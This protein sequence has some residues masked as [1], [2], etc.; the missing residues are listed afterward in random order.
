MVSRRQPNVFEKILLLI[1]ILIV[2]IGY[3]FIYK[4]Y[5]ATGMGLTWDLLSVMFLWLLLAVMLI[6]LAVN[7]NAK[8]ELKLIVQEHLEEIRLLRQELKALSK[9]RR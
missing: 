3:S 6:Q 7:E 4:M 5:L 9:G 8:E 1:G 2:I